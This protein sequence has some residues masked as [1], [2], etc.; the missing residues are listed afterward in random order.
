VPTQGINAIVEITVKNR[1]AASHS[2]LIQMM[3][4]VYLPVIA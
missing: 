2:L 3:G 1:V 4:R